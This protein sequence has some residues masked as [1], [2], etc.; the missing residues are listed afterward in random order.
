MDSYEFMVAVSL[1]TWLQ[2]RINGGDAPDLP[3]HLEASKILYPN[4]RRS[5]ET[6][7]SDGDT[8][9][10]E[11]KIRVGHGQFVNKIIQIEHG[12]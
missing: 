6:I 2:V 7:H 10:C 1:S 12:Q 5:A 9:G 4:L 3:I 8:H 11:R